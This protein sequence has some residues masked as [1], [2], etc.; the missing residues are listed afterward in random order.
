MLCVTVKEQGDRVLIRVGE[1]ECWVS[2]LKIRDNQNNVMLG[3]DADRAKVE[4]VRE[5]VLTRAAHAQAP[6]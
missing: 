5:K 6:Q 1:V 4:I 3:F 2:V